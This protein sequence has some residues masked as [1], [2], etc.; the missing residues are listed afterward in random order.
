MFSR[1]DELTRIDVV[2]LATSYT[3]CVLDA[4]GIEQRTTL[5][6]LLDAMLQQA[7]LERALTVSGW[8]LAAFV[9]LP[10]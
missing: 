5:P 2:S 8:Q 7:D 3:I 4:N 9:R 1:G 6:S 10:V